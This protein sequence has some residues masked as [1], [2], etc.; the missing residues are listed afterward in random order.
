[1]TSAAIERPA[2]RLPAMTS[3]VLRLRGRP[4]PSSSS[5]SGGGA[6]RGRI[7]SGIGGEPIAV[8]RSFSRY[9]AGSSGSSAA[10]AP[11][12]V[13]PDAPVAP[14]TSTVPEEAIGAA[15]EG[16]AGASCGGA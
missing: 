9:S 16:S 10:I 3:M 5:A 7:C 6:R 13:A 2:N 11:D 1:M 15:P 4:S 14:D 12:A 8:R